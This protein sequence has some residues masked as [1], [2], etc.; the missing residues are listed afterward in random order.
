MHLLVT[1][2]GLLLR[3]WMGG[4]Y[5]LIE[6]P[7][8]CSPHTWAPAA[9]RLAIHV[10]AAVVCKEAA[11]LPGETSTDARWKRI[12]PGALSLQWHAAAAAECD[13]ASF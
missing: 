11:R 3:L 4:V 6:R 12:R 8:F 5:R 9:Q 13:Y 2:A 1:L 10:I 7:N